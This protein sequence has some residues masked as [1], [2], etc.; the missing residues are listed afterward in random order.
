VRIYLLVSIH[1]SSTQKVLDE[2]GKFMTE[3]F[4]H[5]VIMYKNFQRLHL[6]TLFDKLEK[7]LMKIPLPG[8]SS[9]SLKAENMSSI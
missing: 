8:R 5:H 9:L 1:F 3:V 4:A 2:Q 6:D 7:D